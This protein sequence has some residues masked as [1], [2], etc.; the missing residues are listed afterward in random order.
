MSVFEDLLDSFSAQITKFTAQ[1][2][3]IKSVIEGDDTTDVDDGNGGSL[4]SFRKVTADVNAHIPDVLAAVDEAET[5]INDGTAAVDLLVTEAETIITDGQAAV[6]EAA[7]NAAASEANILQYAQ[8]AISAASGDALHANVFVSP[9]TLTEN[10]TILE[11][12]NAIGLFT[13]VADGVDIDV[14]GNLI[15]IDEV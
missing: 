1:I 13:D 12:E 7:G 15:I 10:I 11:T 2:A 5:I 3:I 14:A 9:Q 4:P 8:A 6:D